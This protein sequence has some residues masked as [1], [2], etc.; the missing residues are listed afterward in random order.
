MTLLQAIA[1]MEGFYVTGARPQRNNNPG[2]LAGGSESESF[3]ATH[4]DGRYAVF[5]DARTGW[6]ALRR[7]LSVPAR[8]SP[9]QAVPMQPHGPS[10]YLVSGYMGATLEQVIFRFSPPNENNTQLYINTVC[11]D[12]ELPPETILTPELLE[13]P[14]TA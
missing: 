1:K 9:T 6:N 8:F 14:E 13:T 11:N 3:G 10:G 12:T 7:W 5:P 2:D 4:S